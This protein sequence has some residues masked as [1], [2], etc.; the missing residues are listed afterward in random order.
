MPGLPSGPLFAKT[1]FLIE[2]PTEAGPLEN[3]KVTCPAGAV[4]GDLTPQKGGGVTF[5][6]DNHCREGC[7]LRTQCTTSYR[8][9]SLCLHPEERLIQQARVLQASVEGRQKLR[10][11]L[12]VENALGRLA[13]YGI[14]QARYIGRPKTMFQLAMSATVANLRL[15]WNWAADPSRAPLPVGA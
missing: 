12:V 11:R 4:A 13:G 5:H 1:E 14:S 6:F 10:Q 3:A 9:R 8:G 7:P 15:I 2:L